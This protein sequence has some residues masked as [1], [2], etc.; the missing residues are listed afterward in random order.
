MAQKKTVNLD[1]KNPDELRRLLDMVKV[2]P[3]EPAEKEYWVKEIESRLIGHGACLDSLK[4]KQI[5]QDIADGMADISD[6]NNG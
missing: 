6:A 2:G 5:Y 3:L 1:G 4:A